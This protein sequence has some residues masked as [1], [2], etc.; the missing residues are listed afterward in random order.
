MARIYVAINVDM[1]L[2]HSNRLRIHGNTNHDSH[3]MVMHQAA[4][5]VFSAQYNLKILFR[6]IGQPKSVLVGHFQIWLVIIQLE[7][8]AHAKGH[9]GMVAFSTQEKF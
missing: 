9:K 7:Y 6:Q 3:G 8:Y 1:C 2:V 5:E 4:S